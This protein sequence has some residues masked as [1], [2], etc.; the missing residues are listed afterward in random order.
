[1]SAARAAL[2]GVA[3]LVVGV[4]LGAA[5][6]VAGVLVDRAGGAGGPVARCAGMASATLERG[7][8]AILPASCGVWGPVV[9]DPRSGVWHV[10]GC[11]DGVV[12]GVSRGAVEGAGC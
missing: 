2:V 12:W 11:D 10:A 3:V 7:S 9:A 1:M 4:V 8:S 5:L 6:T